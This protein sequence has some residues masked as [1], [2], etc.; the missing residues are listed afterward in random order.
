M[1]LFSVG[2]WNSSV[3]DKAKD[4]GH[5]GVHAVSAFASDLTPAYLEAHGLTSVPKSVAYG[6]TE[7]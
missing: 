7:V 4:S 2:N 1:Y 3:Q 5:I 6:Y